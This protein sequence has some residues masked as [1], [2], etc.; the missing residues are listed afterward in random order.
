MYVQWK[1][2]HR[3]GMRRVQEDAVSLFEQTRQFRVYCSNVMPGMVQQRGYARDLMTVITEFQGTPNDVSDAVESR[4]A[5]GRYLR[6]GSRTFA[7]VLE[8]AVLRYPFGESAEMRDQLCYLLDVMALP[9][10]SLGV[11]PFGTKRKMWPLEAFYM[12]DDR[13]VEAEL[14]SALVAISTPGEIATY[15]KAFKILAGMAVYGPA[16]KAL[17]R[18]AIDA[19]G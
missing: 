9:R 1:Q 16:A 2:L 17:I 4:L 15:A 6:E 19:L 3:D 14:L 11:I 12:F 13:L 7:L 8:E 5:R 18:E 10:V